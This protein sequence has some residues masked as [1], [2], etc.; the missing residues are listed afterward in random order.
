MSSSLEVLVEPVS[1][2][3]SVVAS[4]VSLS[5]KIVSIL[6]AAFMVFCGGSDICFDRRFCKYLSTANE[7]ISSRSVSV[8]ILSLIFIINM[9]CI[10]ACFIDS[11]LSVN[12]SVSKLKALST[13]ELDPDNENIISPSKHKFGY[14]VLLWQNTFPHSSL[15]L[16]PW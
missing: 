9:D 6:E 15:A 8:H 2:S 13:V 1:V 4:S 12:R 10:V 11:L 3:S 5:D 7:K 16:T 14:S